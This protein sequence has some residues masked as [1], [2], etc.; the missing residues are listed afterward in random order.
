VYFVVPWQEELSVSLCVFRAP[1]QPSISTLTANLLCRCDRNWLQE[2][3]T[4]RCCNGEI[5]PRRLG[6]FIISMRF[7]N[8]DFKSDSF[9]RKHKMVC[10]PTNGSSPFGNSFLTPSI[11][12]TTTYYSKQFQMAAQVQNRSNGHGI[13]MPLLRKKWLCQAKQH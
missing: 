3:E 2:S 4:N 5:I 12:S 8:R 1:L 11:N 6:H 13:S 10:P 7:R 9:S